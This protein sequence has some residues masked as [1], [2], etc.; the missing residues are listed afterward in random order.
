MH[1]LIYLTGPQGSG[2]SLLAQN[3]MKSQEFT[4]VHGTHSE[5]DEILKKVERNESYSCTIIIT[6]QREAP[7]PFTEGRLKNFAEQKRIMFHS[8]NLKKSNEWLRG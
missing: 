5:M 4:V 6:E 7:S 1:T 8:I 3:F 2:K